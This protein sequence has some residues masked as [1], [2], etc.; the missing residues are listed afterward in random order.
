MTRTIIMVT[1]LSIFACGAAKSKSNSN[2]T[3]LPKTEEVN[4]NVKPSKVKVD[5]EEAIVLPV[6]QGEPCPNKYG[7]DSIKTLENYSLYRSYLKQGSI[8]D[9]LVGWRYIF[10]KAPCFRETTYIDGADIYQGKIEKEKDAKRKMQLYD[11]IMMIHDRRAESFPAKRGYIMGRKGLDIIK[12]NQED[13]AG[14][15]KAISESVALSKNETEYFIMQ[16]YFRA[17]LKK[18]AST[19]KSETETH[20]ILNIYFNLSKICDYNI[21]NQ[22]EEAYKNGY[23]A[24]QE[25]IDGDLAGT[26]V[27]DCN[28]IKTIFGKKFETSPSPS[29]ANLLYV[30]LITKKC[31]DDPLFLKVLETKIKN[32]PNVRSSILLANKY[33]EKK[34][35]VK[36]Q[37]VLNNAVKLAED[38]ND[39]SDLLMAQAGLYA[40]QGNYAAAR[41]KAIES[42]KMG[43]NAGEAYF[44]IAGL[45]AASGAKCSGDF[46]GQ[47]V[48]FIAVDT[49]IKAKSLDPS[50]AERVN[51]KTAK[52]AGY[53][54]TKEEVFFK[55]RKLGESISIGCWIGGTSVIRSR[56]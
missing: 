35:Y 48:Y 50:L 47:E 45:Y 4:A 44:F 17:E 36:A 51:A 53:Y 1:L 8:E 32:D 7:V 54:P 56:D 37:E 16:P 52:L 9:A 27:K 19:D 24:A 21:K 11:T 20:K 25:G 38:N 34:E 26:F 3:V 6:A 2:P 46:G 12:Y 43:N 22:T 13:L 42:S 14:I 29:L 31:T 55:N 39:K 15:I 30:L 28:D 18:F 10:D 49:Y 5:I 41:D 40:D 33:Q 23:K